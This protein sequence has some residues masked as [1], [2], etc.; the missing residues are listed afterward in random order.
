[1]LD[2]FK[3]AL[4]RYIKREIEIS[5]L[6]DNLDQLLK[7]HPQ[8]A[9]PIEQQI[10][11]LV[12]DKKISSD[13]KTTIFYIT[14]K[15]KATDS[16]DST[17][18]SSDAD[19]ATRV[20]AGSDDDATAV[21]TDLPTDLPQDDFQIDITSGNT[22]P[23]IGP[24]G[25][26]VMTHG[27]DV[28][29]VG[30]ILRNRFELTQKLGEGGMG[31]V[32]R[33]TDKIKAEAQDKNPTVAVKV[34]NETFKQ[35][36]ESF[37]ALQRESSKQ[38]RLAHPNI[39]TVFD[40]DRDY[41]YGTVFMTMELLD[42]E[43]LDKFIARIPPGGLSYEKAQ[44]V[45]EGMCHGL[46][47]AHHHQL[48]H[49][50]FKP[51]NTFLNKDGVVKLLDFGI[52]RAAKPKDGSGGQDATLF[53]PGTLGALTPAY[54]SAEMLEGKT[55]EPSDDIYA[56][57]CVTY[58]LLSGRHPFNKMP[59]DQAR[60]NKLTPKR[61]NKIK[62]RQMNGLIKALS[63]RRATRTQTV[64]Q[65]LDEI[66]PKKPVL[67]YA[68]TGAFVTLTI[69]GL[70]A[71]GAI[72]DHFRM[73]RNQELI[74]QITQAGVE[75]NNPLIAQSL[76]QLGTFDNA[77]NTQIK[78]E[79]NVQNTILTYFSQRIDQA[80][81]HEKMRYDYPTA[82]TILANA[83]EYYPDS[84]VLNT[85]E[86]EIN[87]KKVQTL[88]NQRDLYTRF[89]KTGPWLA[90]DGDNNDMPE[91][92]KIIRTIEP[93]NALLDDPRL[94]G[95]YITEARGSAQ[96]GNFDRAMQ[97]L[98]QTLIFTE[99]QKDI[100]NVIDELVFERY[101][102]Q[103]RENLANRLLSL[104]EIP[105]IKTLSDALAL[106]DDLTFIQVID[107]NNQLLQEQPDN[108]MSSVVGLVSPKNNILKKATDTIT[109]LFLK[110][111][112][113]HSSILETEN[114][115][116]ALAPALN[117]EQRGKV[118]DALDAN[119]KKIGDIDPTLLQ[120][121]DNAI[122]ALTTEIKNTSL[123][124]E[125]IHETNQLLKF[126]VNNL[127]ALVGQENE[128]TEQLLRDLALAYLQQASEIG[129]D[130]QLAKANILIDYARY[131]DSATPGLDETQTQ[132]S[133]A[134]RQRENVRLEK[135]R[136]AIINALKQ[137]TLTKAAAEQTDQAL[138]FLDLLKVYL[139]PDDPF[140]TTEGP[141]AIGKAYASIALRDKQ[142]SDNI[143]NDF[144]SQRS[145]YT[146]A[147]EH[148]DEGSKVA[149]NSKELR[150]AR[151]QIQYALISASA[152]HTFSTAQQLDI[153]DLQT[154]LSELQK[155]DPNAYQQL[156]TEF[157]EAVA[158]RIATMEVYSPVSAQQFLDS[159][160]QLPLNQALLSRIRV[161]VV[162]PSK[163]APQLEQAIK[164]S[165]LSKAG[166]I[167][168][169]AKNEESDH[170]DIKRLRTVLA[171][172]VNTAN[173][174]YKDYL[175]ALKNNDSDSAKPLIAQAIKIWRDNPEFIAAFKSIKISIVASKA[176]CQGRLAGYGKR[177]RG[178]C[179]DMVS[180]KNQGP[181]MVV[182][183]AGA[184]QQ[185]PFAISKYEV[186]IGDF[187]HYCSKTKKCQVSSEN[188]KLPVTNITLQQAQDYAKWLSEITGAQYR[189]PTLTEWEYAA[190][191]NGDQPK[192]KTY[193]CT[194]RLGEQI[195]KGT[196]LEDIN[197]GRQNGWGL[198][199]YIGNAQEWVLSENGVKARGGAY[200]DAL[201]DCAI[202]LERNHNGDADSITSFRLIRAV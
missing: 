123:N 119:W 183:P 42:G 78:A 176:I 28:I 130:D 148:L 8:L 38:Q 84:G 152:R 164:E 184:G 178:R 23:T 54:A 201:Q 132:I 127:I 95:S 87:E 159:S 63:F 154:K 65:F 113:V 198:A 124:S 71:R 177:S 103:Q 145:G 2:E 21:N 144:I 93:T 5:Q 27:T 19:D 136:I 33:A 26:P 115:F 167:F 139:T 60:K 56:L 96:E 187:N 182:L 100:I 4:Q 166:G 142:R 7:K 117:T 79:E 126:K 68:L 64:E 18:L 157:S 161:A 199:N 40:F 67:A 190:N 137:D 102:N 106:K 196:G 34:L 105:A 110:A 41:T 32:F 180:T 191:A 24:D 107:P 61:I 94:I 9:L 85:K 53:D 17:V 104:T 11:Q 175:R 143:K 35:F 10:D 179:Y 120:S 116:Q 114:T 174:A 170:P 25:M 156:Q 188:P 51:A 62:R 90:V 77:S 55:P 181:I 3:T 22:A 160:K 192:G 134:L 13:D 48:V 151:A 197:S 150:V 200:S 74:T 81:N 172:K 47:Y 125:A 16:G 1:M 89:L 46:A 171:N 138:Q 121:R 162:A 186:S 108:L 72:E 82:Y 158:N 36:R 168:N 185:N 131:F 30:S 133:A 73:Q 58:Q 140:L 112:T 49:S 163:Y 29:N 70:L 59:A 31:A 76:E 97:L 202:G 12:L 15:Y 155:F 98:E 122:T 39:A 91:V 92:V 147:L 75:Q 50:D 149:P 88:Q 44:P 173:K 109:K 195:I 69:I 135:E 80:I 189:I 129:A 165:L 57:A 20:L 169:E 141:N 45:I 193:N 153:E 111:A 6:I 118:R 52:A 43:P 37:I 83:K 14:A 66:T 86:T 99:D 194:L 146:A 128:M 101:Q